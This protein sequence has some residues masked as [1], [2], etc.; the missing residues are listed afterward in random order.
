MRFLLLLLLLILPN[1]LLSQIDTSYLNVVSWNIQ[2]FG[3][4]KSDEELSYISTKIKFYDIL[5]IQEVSTSEFGS[6]AVA[7]LADNLDRTGSDW[8]YVI[9]NSTS[10]DGSE[11]YAYLFKKNRVK[12][13]EKA[14]LEMSLS[15]VM[16]REP[17]RAIFIFKNIEYYFFN[18]HLVPTDKHP[19]IEVGKLQ[20][21]T[22]LY[23][24]KRIIM[25]GDFNLSQSD[26]SF[27]SLKSKGFVASLVNKKTSLKMKP[28][29]GKVLNMEY[30]NFFISSQI[31]FKNSSVIYFFEDFKDLQSAR[32]IS[33]HCPIKI[34]IK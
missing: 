23:T 33:D 30:D 1:L 11:R 3:K 20:V 6:Q 9:S 13:K 8:D 2:N 18:L 10:G 22:T 7:K 19:H 32:K 31:K 21:L 26:N 28:V 29:S 5:A 24:G 27:N 14:Q 34:S 16:N 17:F 12:L 4:S 25:L 15:E